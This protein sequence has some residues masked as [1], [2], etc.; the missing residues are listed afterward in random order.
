MGSLKNKSVK[1]SQETSKDESLGAIGKTFLNIFQQQY[2]REKQLA[3]KIKTQNPNIVIVSGRD[4]KPGCVYK[5]LD[6][7]LYDKEFT[8]KSIKK[9][10]IQAPKTAGGEQYILTNEGWWVTEYPLGGND[11]FIQVKCNIKGGKSR[12]NKSRSKLN[13][14]VNKSIKIFNV[15]RT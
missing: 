12:K 9:D 11:K 15:R 13:K 6:S 14:K 5:F 7:E 10:S 8:V 3:D 2:D 1:K 4:L